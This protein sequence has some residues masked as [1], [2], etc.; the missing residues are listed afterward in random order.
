MFN[1]FAVSD[2]VTPLVPMSN[3]SS[4]NPLPNEPV[5]VDEPLMFP[6]ASIVPTTCNSLVGVLVE[7]I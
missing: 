2:N 5:D 4:I 3:L 6:L 7:P 1:P